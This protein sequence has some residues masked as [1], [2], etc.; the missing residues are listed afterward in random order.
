[1]HAYVQHQHN[2]QQHSS[3]VTPT[4]P[5]TTTTGQKEEITTEEKTSHNP[6]QQHASESGELPEFPSW[7]GGWQPASL[8]ILNVVKSLDTCMS[9]PRRLRTSPSQTHTHR[10]HGNARMDKKKHIR[11]HRGRQKKRKKRTVLI[12]NALSLS[13]YAL[14]RRFVL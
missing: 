3:R 6:K 14:F 9:S 12:S 7:L 4:F 5:K 8:T 13:T 11:T 10:C 2:T 1:M